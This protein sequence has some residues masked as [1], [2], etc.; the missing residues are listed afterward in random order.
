MEEKPIY[1]LKA[2]QQISPVF[3]NSRVLVFPSL[4]EAWGL[5][6]NEGMQCGVP[7]IA[8]P[9][10]GASDAIVASCPARP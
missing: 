9:F 10:T 1:V 2:G 4:W 8:S 3:E 5:V 7:A 6:C